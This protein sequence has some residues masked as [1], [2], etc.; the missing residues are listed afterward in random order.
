MSAAVLMLLTLFVILGITATSL[1]RC[2]HASTGYQCQPRKSHHWGIYAPYFTSTSKLPTIL[3]DQCTVTF[4]Q[5]LSRHGARFPN[6][7]NL[8]DCRRVMQQIK[9]TARSYTGQY[10]FLEHYRFDLREG[11]L[12][13]F[14]QSQMV[15]SGA[16]FFERYAHLAQKGDIFVRSASSQRIVMSA[17]NFTSGFHQA[18]S[19][20]VNGKTQQTM[21][22]SA[23][24]MSH[25]NVTPQPILVLPETTGQNSSL[26]PATCSAF[27][28][29]P[30]DKDNRDKWAAK[31]VPPIMKRLN[32]DLGTSLQLND[33]VP[34]MDMCP[35]STVADVEGRISPFCALFTPQEWKSYNY[36]YTISVYYGWATGNPLGPSQGIAWGN[37]LIARLTRKPVALHGPVNATLARDPNTFPLDRSL[38]A[39]FTHENHM[40]S[41]FFA[42]GLYD[43]RPPVPNDRNPDAFDTATASPF[44]S[45]MYV[46]R[47]QCGAKGRRKTQELVRVL[48]NDRVVPL[49][50]C[51]ADAYGRCPLDRFITGLRYIRHGGDWNKCFHKK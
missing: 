41:M 19:H 22:D 39:D 48:I 35:F 13:S 50:G 38:Y 14:G 40:V 10:K 20:R 1:A 25:G 31:F 44:A 43:P 34:L 30:Y 51:G 49:R 3:P 11:D 7:P 45:R 33:V 5:I 46:E 18:L 37:E 9:S 26:A 23:E 47:M 8:D 24:Y 16:K 6:K 2:L 12:T 28:P 17:V 36:Y 29:G 4:A 42:M 21:T 32:H 27:N 15:H